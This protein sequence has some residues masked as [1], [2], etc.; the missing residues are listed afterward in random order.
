MVFA[1]TLGYRYKRR[2]TGPSCVR[3]LFCGSLTQS[4]TLLFPYQFHRRRLL[5]CSS[6]F[7]QSAHLWFFSLFPK[8]FNT[9]NPNSHGFITISYRT[10]SNF[11]AFRQIFFTE[12]YSF[13]TQKTSHGQGTCI[14]KQ[15]SILFIFYTRTAFL[16]FT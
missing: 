7:H 3:F 14:T 5:V 2:P 1:R 6:S 11:R 15:F 8:P 10:S 12:L 13:W 4:V 9:F 16:P